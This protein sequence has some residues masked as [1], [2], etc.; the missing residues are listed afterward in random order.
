MH[1]HINTRK[2]LKCNTMEKNVAGMS[3]KNAH[4]RERKY[5]TLSDN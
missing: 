5:Y 4:E 3:D 2:E 1:G